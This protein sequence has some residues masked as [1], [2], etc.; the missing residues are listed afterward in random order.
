VSVALPRI[1]RTSSFHL[2][3]AYA[4]LFGASVVILFG[5]IYWATN[6][7]MA[8]SGCPRPAAGGRFRA[9]TALNRPD[10]R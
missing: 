8:N 7:Y 1:L 4:G 2:T 9:M 3:L 5:V 6:V 10:V